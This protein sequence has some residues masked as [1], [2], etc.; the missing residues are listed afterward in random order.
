LVSKRDAEPTWLL[1]SAMLCK[2]DVNTR[3]AHVVESVDMNRRSAWVGGEPISFDRLLLATGAA[4]RALRIPG[5]GLEGV[6]YLRTMRDA[7]RIRSALSRG[8]PLVVIGGGFIGLEVAASARTVGCPVTVIEAGPS[9]MGRA[10]PPV[11]SDVF[12]E[13][14]GQH[15]VCIELGRRPVRLLGTQ[16]VEAVQLDDGRVLPAAAVVVGIGVT[17][18]VSL[19]IQIGAQ[20]DDG[21]VVDVDGRTSVADVF[22]AGDCCRVRSGRARGVRLEAW[23]SALDQ[24]DRAAH[25]IL[26]LKPPPLNYA[27]MWSNQYDWQLQI[28]GAPEE[29][30]DVVA[31]GDVKRGELICFQLREGRLVGAVAVNRNRDLA[32]VRRTLRAAPR[33]D[34]MNLS[35]EQWQLRRLLTGP[36]PQHS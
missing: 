36:A 31:R 30:H 26:G 25:T 6:F 8:P 12:A 23:Q 21:I 10:V 22:A 35:D 7:W 20:T 24:G 16:S 18:E 2:L 28:A 17:P 11:I 9:L 29:V 15:G 32:I 33:V 13:K 4:P 5:V 3:L 34:P 19:G 27:W 14:H 1:D